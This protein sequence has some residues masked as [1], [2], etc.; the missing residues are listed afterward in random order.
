M[1]I[2]VNLGLA[3]SGQ[4]IEPLFDVCYV[5]P[6]PKTQENV[7]ETGCVYYMT[8]GATSFPRKCL[9]VSTLRSVKVSDCREALLPVYVTE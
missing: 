3:R 7:H 5:S 1:G 2:V 8:R 6:K 4:W 9:L